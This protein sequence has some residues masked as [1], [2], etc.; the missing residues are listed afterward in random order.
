[1]LPYAA[2][3]PVFP[4]YYFCSFQVENSS[5][6]FS[7]C[8]EKELRRG[9][10]GLHPEQNRLISPTWEEPVLVFTRRIWGKSGP[11]GSLFILL[12]FQLVS[13]FL[14]LSYFQFLFSP[15]Q[16]LSHPLFSL[17]VSFTSFSI[18]HFFHFFYSISQ[19]LFT[20]FFFI[21][22]SFHF[23]F[24]YLSFFHFLFSLYLSF[25]HFLFS[26]S[27]SLSLPLLSILVSFT[28]SFL[29]LSFF[30]IHFSLLL[31]SSCG[32]SLTQS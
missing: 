29:F 32:L 28:S 5:F 8:L 27:H 30:H 12:T 3:L 10:G 17:S 16:F 23:L 4:F 13:S 18:S 2:F 15:S 6:K 22:I 24:L 11:K 7:V 26:S 31:S 20:S 21:S 14:F 1:M 19:F 25:F 9:R